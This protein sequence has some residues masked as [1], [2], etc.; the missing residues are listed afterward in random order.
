VLFAAVGYGLVSWRVAAA[1]GDCP[2]PAGEVWLLAL[3]VAVA[4]GAFGSI[5]L[6]FAAD[7]RQVRRL[8][9]RDLWVP[10]GFAGVGAVVSWWAMVSAC[11]ETVAT[12][13]TAFGAG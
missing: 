1:A 11:T 2:A 3:S 4:W 5:A 6:K 9:W 7:A 10:L 12:L 8:P 13:W